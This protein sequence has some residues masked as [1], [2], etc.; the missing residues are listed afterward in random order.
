MERKLYFCMFVGWAEME[1]DSGGLWGRYCGLK[2]RE[3][4]NRKN[5]LLF[6]VTNLGF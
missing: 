5:L 2:V 1:L 6:C 4:G 3:K